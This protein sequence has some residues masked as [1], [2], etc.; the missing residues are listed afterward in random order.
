MFLRTAL[1][2]VSAAALSA[3]AQAADPCGM[4]GH[5]GCDK[6][7]VAAPAHPYEPSVLLA[8]AL[9]DKQARLGME[10]PLTLAAANALAAMYKGLGRYKDAEFLYLRSLGACERTL[11]LKHS[12]T[13]GTLKGLAALYE[14]E[15]RQYEAAL[16]Y[17]RAGQAEPAQLNY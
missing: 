7:A 15:G 17:K 12:L 13:I 1:T 3:A 16:L 5:A 11:G 10:H 14:A 2:I 9:A 8:T 6:P 4:P